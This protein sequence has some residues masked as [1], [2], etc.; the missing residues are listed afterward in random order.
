MRLLRWLSRLRR[1]PAPVRRVHGFERV[2]TLPPGSF[3]TWNL[4]PEERD[5]WDE[6]LAA[7]LPGRR[8]PARGLDVPD[9][10]LDH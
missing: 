10:W 3:V 6:R 7:R 9:N 2:P 8:E 4:S 1:R 5:E